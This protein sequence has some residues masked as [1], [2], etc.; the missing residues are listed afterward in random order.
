M[1]RAPTRSCSRRPRHAYVE[2]GGKF[3]MNRRAGITRG[4][5]GNELRSSRSFRC[6]SAPTTPIVFKGGIGH[7]N[8]AHLHNAGVHM[9]EGTAASVLPV[10]ACADPAWRQRSQSLE[11][12]PDVTKVIA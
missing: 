8:V 7:G 10:D 6:P 11:D 12:A 4:S 1:P 5:P 9:Y 2:S 3:A